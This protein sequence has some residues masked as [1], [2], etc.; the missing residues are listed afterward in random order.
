[1][2]EQ[3]EGFVMADPNSRLA[4]LQQAMTE[5]LMKWAEVQGI[6]RELLAFMLANTIGCLCFDVPP[7]QEEKLYRYLVDTIKANVAAQQR[8]MRAGGTA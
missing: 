1:M 7:D 2:S 6:N 3:P 4:K 5:S 8:H